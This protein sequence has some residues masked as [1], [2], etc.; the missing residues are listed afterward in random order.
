MKLSLILAASV[1]VALSG[2]ASAK[3]KTETISLNGHCDVLT[4]NIDKSV[5]AGT[6][7]PD[8]AQGFG[9]G[10]IGKIKG[11]GNAIVA[12]V[13]FSGEP[14]EQV[15]IRVQYPLVTGGDWD[16]W[17]TSNGATLTKLESGT[18]TVEGTAARGARGT[19]SVVRDAVKGT[20][21]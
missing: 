3:S 8:C 4:L 1:L 11:F 12:G 16:L 2:G 10:F 5:V 18:Y 9:G 15:V 7:D 20:G 14:G 21:E 17:G 13:Q 19:T 6:D